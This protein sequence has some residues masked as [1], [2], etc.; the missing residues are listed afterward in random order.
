MG[1]H[2]LISNVLG[3]FSGMSEVSLHAESE[4]ITTDLQM[5][6]EE[7]HKTEESLRSDLDDDN[8]DNYESVDLD[9]DHCHADDRRE[10]GGF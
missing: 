5:D 10:D 7:D 8:D 9:K 3:L 6:Y 4:A 2:R 1:A